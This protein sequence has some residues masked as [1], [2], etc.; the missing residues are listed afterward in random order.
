MILFLYKMH[1]LLTFEFDILNNIHTEFIGF[2]LSAV[3]VTNELLIGR[4][5]GG[6]AILFHRCLSYALNIVETTNSRLTAF[7]LDSVDGPVLFINCYLP[8]DYG[9]A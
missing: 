3:N 9:D 7:T 8:T 5:Y 2:G 6:T 4:P 1:W